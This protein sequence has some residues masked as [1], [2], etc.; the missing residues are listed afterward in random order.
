MEQKITLRVPAF[1]VPALKGAAGAKVKDMCT[2]SGAW[3]FI[4]SPS[5]GDPFTEVSVSGTAQSVRTA[6]LL[7]KMAVLHGRAGDKLTPPEEYKPDKK[8]EAELNISVFYRETQS[9]A[10]NTSYHS[11]AVSDSNEI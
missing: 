7:I 8:A 6:S 1:S 2:T 3:I 9:R 11:T 5:L 10:F 4:S